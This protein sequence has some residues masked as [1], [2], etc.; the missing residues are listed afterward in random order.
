M[1]V[2]VITED[3]LKL[4]QQ[5]NVHW[6]DCEYGAPCIDPKRP[7]GNSSVALDIAQLLGWWLPDEETCD[8][9]DDAMEAI[10]TEA[11]ELHRQME[12]VLQIVLVTQSFKAGKYVKPDDYSYRSWQREPT[13]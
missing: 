13:E 6:H 9:Y 11:N 4:L 12:T 2:F 8:D 7:Y 5:M 3:H 1:N 10:E